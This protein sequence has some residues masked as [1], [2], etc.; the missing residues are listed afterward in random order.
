MPY[1]SAGVSTVGSVSYT[2]LDV[3]KRQPHTHHPA[4]S[5][6][7]LQKHSVAWHSEYTHHASQYLSLI[8]SSSHFDGG[9]P[10][11]SGKTIQLA[12][13]GT[14]NAELAALFAP[15]P[16]L[17]VSDGGD[18]TATVPRLEYP[19]FQR[20]YGCYGA[21]DKVSNVHLPQERHEMCIR[22]SSITVAAPT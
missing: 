21:T 15:R 2:H 11:E 9:C 8:H 16:M 17:V 12:G 4:P 13:G 18:L 1:Q 14:C 3:Y 6:C 22:D 5:P 20:I 10:C 7:S 19:Y